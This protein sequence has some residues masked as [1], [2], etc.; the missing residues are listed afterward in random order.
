M[1]N[2]RAIRGASASRRIVEI[3]ETPTTTNGG[4]TQKPDRAMKGT[5]G[6][7]L[8]GVGTLIHHA[9]THFSRP[10]LNQPCEDARRRVLGGLGVGLYGCGWL[11]DL[12]RGRRE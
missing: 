5:I 2:P 4:A 9:T 7:C 6:L 8:F 3:I 10:Y 12:S 11:P 1:S